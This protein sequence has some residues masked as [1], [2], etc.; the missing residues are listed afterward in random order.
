VS[1]HVGRAVSS[2]QIVN[3]NSG[4]LWVT[5]DPDASYKKTRAAVDEVVNGYAGLDREVATYPESRV[6]DLLGREEKQVNVRVFGIDQGVMRSKAEE[7]RDAIADIDGVVDERVDG[8]VEEPGLQVE[9][10][11]VAAQ[12][13]GVVTG[14]VRR[15]ASALLSGIQ[16]G[17]IFERQKVF[18]VLVIATPQTRTNLSGVGG[19]LIN[20]PDGHVPLRDLAKVQV[21]P[22]PTVIRHD[23]ASRS[24][25]V[26]AS[27]SGRQ[28]DA[29]IAD[30]ERAVAGVRMPLE[31]H[32]ELRR[33]LV[34]EQ[35][36]QRRVLA[37]ALGAAVVILLLLQASFGSWRLA[38]LLWALLPLT[39]VGG[40]VAAHAAPRELTVGAFAGLFA[41]L[42][43][44]A[45]NGIMMIRRF[46][47]LE[48]DEGRHFGPD[49]VLQG[50]RER[51]AP[52][53]ATA[54]AT[55]LVMLPFVVLGDV[56]G[57][58]VVRP[59]AIVVLGGLVT[60]TSVALFVLPG[61]YLLLGRGQHEV[62]AAPGSGAP[63]E[64]E[65]PSTSREP[66]PAEI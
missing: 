53:L 26:T 7:I 36:S 33:G 31:Y 24:V 41:V 44:A 51:M 9:V 42:G 46:Q 16:V 64:Q 54:A 52:V 18:E 15:A 11:L 39:V 20:K 57:L 48:R 61:V 47:A 6:H 23:A 2:D 3:V 19:L 50:A 56:A 17:S 27:V 22:S 5:L 65:A 35:D 1:G 25:D 14:D 30:V 62:A 49:L 10:D 55:A 37:I 60:S 21:A 40:L 58:E 63:R 13:H 66:L 32:V 45:R 28:L 4:E 34:D 38:F 12:R 59:M 43:I 8:Q 29:V